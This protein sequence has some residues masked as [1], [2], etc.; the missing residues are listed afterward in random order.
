LQDPTFKEFDVVK[1]G[2]TYIG[3]IENLGERPDKA[4]TPVAQIVV[5][6]FKIAYQIS[7][8]GGYGDHD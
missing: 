6:I 3:C 7:E 8:L 4:N 5:Y 2:S 1:Q